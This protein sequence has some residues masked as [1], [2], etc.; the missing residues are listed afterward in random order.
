MPRMPGRRACVALLAALLLAAPLAPGAQADPG[1]Q[2]A[3]VSSS[4]I[5]QRLPQGF[6]GVSVEYPALPA[7]AGS[8]PHAIDPVLIALLKGIAQGHAPIVRVGGDSTDATWWPVRHLIPPGGLHYRLTSNWVQTAHAFAADLRAKLILGINLEAD[9]PRIAAAEG[10]AFL[11][12]IGRQYIDALEI[13][14]E[15]DLYSVFPWFTDRHHHRHFARRRHYNLGKYTNEFTRWSRVLPRLPLAGP[16]TSGPNWMRGLAHFVSAEPGLGMVTYHRY[17][18]RAC[19]TKPSSAGYPSIANL[20]ANRSSS[21][22]AKPLAAFVRTAHHHHL[23]FRLTELNSA[24]CEGTAG[25]SDTFASALWAL[26][27]LFNVAQA[28]VDGVNFHMLPGSHYEL[29]SP[30]QT[31]TGSWQ[32]VV[33]P[34]YYGLLMFAQAFPPGAKLL[35]GTSSG[36]PVKVWATR[37]GAGVMRVTLINQ[38]ASNP[39]TVQV[40][41]PDAAGTGSLETLEAPSVSATTGVT[42]GGQTFGA[43]TT[44]GQLPGSPQTTPVA[45]AGGVYTVQ[46][47]AGSAAL[48]TATPSSGGG[49]TGL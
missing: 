31:A 7:Y 27:T 19:V 25:V 35:S 36:G 15:P 45:P 40:R 43:V 23:P 9:R 28:G 22:L 37:D 10:K 13:G 4:E 14:N 49:G 24:S 47:P 34:E 48:L 2:L 8:D 12:G 21:G 17:P 32:A 30:S 20:L 44:T 6:L 33:H 46:L 26:D 18:L 29:F 11:H 39:H 1:G 16:V 5:G 3:T 42:L 41:L 38:D